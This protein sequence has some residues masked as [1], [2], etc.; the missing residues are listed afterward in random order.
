MEIEKKVKNIDEK[1]GIETINGVTLLRGESLSNEISPC[2]AGLEKC[3]PSH[4]WGPGIRTY[5]LVHI[6]LSG[7]GKVKI[8]GSEYAV[9]KNQ[10][11]LI[12][13]DELI[14]YEA[15]GKEPWHYAWF[16]IRG[17]KVP[18]LV[19]RATLGKRVFSVAPELG[20]ELTSLLRSSVNE[21]ELAFRLT[22]FAYKFLGLAYSSSAPEQRKPDIVQTAVRFI[23]NNYFRPFDITW[24][25][26]ELGVSRTHFSTLFTSV[27]GDSPY[28][29]LV[30]YRV[31]KA[32]NLLI[33]RGDLSV[34]EV[35]YSVGFSSIE[36]FSEMF[37]KYSGHSPLFYRK[38]N[39]ID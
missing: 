2:D 34:T 33:T 21:V 5:Y 24:L 7:K 4:S 16:G 22:A 26:S 39:K 28:S 11:F 29:Y 6:V 35:A 30:K 32:Q 9:T 14:Y 37:K 38:K 10:A 1:T 27:M 36:R 20:Y 3:L 31:A 12:R 8:N 18:Y 25:A 17:D 15:D 23:E 19:E 13:P